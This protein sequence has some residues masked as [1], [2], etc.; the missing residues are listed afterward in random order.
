[1]ETVDHCVG[2]PLRTYTTSAIKLPDPN[3]ELPA[4]NIVAMV[5]NKNKSPPPPIFGQL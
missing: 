2:G 1:M 5:T 3:V 4:H